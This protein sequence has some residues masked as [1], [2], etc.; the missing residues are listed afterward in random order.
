MAD[1]LPFII[2]LMILAVF[3]RAESALTI[4]YMIIG[5]F[6]LGLWWNKKSL[7]HIKITRQ[8]ENHA[9]FGE[10]ISV[11]VNIE[12]K[13]ILPILWL[14][15]HESL[16]V[17]LRAGRNVKQVFSLGIRG[18]KEIEY[19]L[20]AFKRGYYSLGPLLA[21][22]GDPLGLVKPHQTEFASD[23]LTVYPQIV[24]LDKL[25][26]PSRSP[27]GTLKHH[28]PIYED[29]SRTMGKRE[30]QSGDSMRRI[31]W[32]SSASSG[33]LQ[34]KLYKASIA[35]EVSILLDLDKNSYDI[36]SFYDDT[37]LAVVAA[38]SLAAWGKRHK[39]AI[40]LVTN[41]IDPSQENKMPKP[42]PP[43]KGA[44]HLINILE[45][46]ARIQPGDALSIDSL[47]HDARATL[48]W[49]TTIVL[50]SGSLR[51]DVLEQLFQARKTGLN[52]VVILTGHPG[53]LA[54]QQ[55]LAELYHI[56]LHRATYP[57]DL[58]TINHGR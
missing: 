50:I 4:F 32:K 39:Q 17:N 30:Y 23:P 34:T 21:H 26:L 22:S 43:K 44:G 14:E 55:K 19:T 9:F 45:I 41:G 11:I 47:I 1:Y 27:F 33:Q 51:D 46:L 13:S 2:F 25:G 7:Q 49:G 48:S 5:T 16:P 29:P 10:D 36:K 15:I 57:I 8:Y 38:A 37:E 12:N 6:L 31:D 18:K 58:E 53:D 3:L 35:L 28:N 20:S 52:P 24:N 54:Q 56:P 42:V 40:G